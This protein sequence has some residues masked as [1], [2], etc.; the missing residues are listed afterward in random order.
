LGLLGWLSWRGVKPA[1]HRKD[2]RL[3]CGW[4]ANTNEVL[5][6]LRAPRL[7]RA[8]WAVHLPS[9]SLAVR[10]MHGWEHEN[11]VVDILTLCPFD[12]RGHRWNDLVHA[13]ASACPLH[14][15]MQDAAADAASRASRQQC[16]LIK[17]PSGADA[18]HHSNLTIAARRVLVWNRDMSPKCMRSCVTMCSTQDTP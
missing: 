14:A 7:S 15:R 11:I 6:S 3:R 16:P 12:L 8:W 2:V 4:L 18:C 17:A 10:S 13:H 5:G 1:E 9:G